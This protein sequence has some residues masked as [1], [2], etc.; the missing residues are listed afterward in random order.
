[1]TNDKNIRYD[2]Q[3]RIQNWQQERLANAKIAII[4]SGQ[5]AQFTAASLVALGVGNVEIYCNEKVNGKEF[6]TF[7]SNGDDKS[8]LLEKKLHEMNPDANVRSFKMESDDNILSLVDNPDIILELTNSSELKERIMEYANAHNVK[9]ISASTGKTGGELYFVKPG[10]DYSSAKLTKYDGEKQR[11]FTSEIFGGMITEEVRKILMPLKEGEDAVKNLAYDATAEKRFSKEGDFDAQPFEDLSQK[12]IL[13][14]GA[15]A[16]GNFVAL[17]ATLEGIGKIDI[18]DFDEVE[19]HNLN[20]QIM[21]YDAVGKKKSLALAEKIKQI[22]PDIEVKGLVEKLDENTTYFLNN[23][24]DLILDCVDNFATRAITNYFAVH[25]G[26]PLVSGGT[27]SNSGQVVVYEP[28]QSA[29][30]ECKL[31]VE[32]ALGVALQGSKCTDAP[33]PSV[34]MTN[35]II[36]GMMVGEALKVL[37]KGYG[38]SV[39]RILKYDSTAPVRGGLIGASNACE[40]SRGEIKEWLQGVKE[41]FSLAKD[42]K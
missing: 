36:G 3:Q 37:D 31:G 21:F 18:L 34:I 17:G 29:C 30:L 22:N 16:L 12:R 20:R 25:Y 32:Q 15:G 42:E 39:S 38:T 10:D 8:S 28:G 23:N 11:T 41:M 9:I 2:R 6:L 40:C 5:L 1:M 24:P 13:I 19:P 35:E 14:I 26:I 4:G 33:N 27:N 7:D